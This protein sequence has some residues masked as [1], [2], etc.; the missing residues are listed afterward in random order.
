[1]ICVC[2]NGVFALIYFSLLLPPN[3]EKILLLGYNKLEVVAATNEY[4]F[5]GKSVGAIPTD[6]FWRSSNH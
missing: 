6:F 4:I 1:P 2:L 3:I 5:C